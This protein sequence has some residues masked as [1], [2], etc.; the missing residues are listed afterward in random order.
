M[1]SIDRVTTQAENTNSSGDV[2][3]SRSPVDDKVDA[4]ARTVLSPSPILNRPMHKS[5]RVGSNLNMLS[6]VACKILVRLG[7]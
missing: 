2:A 4:A 7:H 6:T 5:P 1:K 3:R